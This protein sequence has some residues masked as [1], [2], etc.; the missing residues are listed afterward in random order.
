MIKVAIKKY[1]WC[2]HFVKISAWK[3]TTKG[4]IKKRIIFVLIFLGLR[5]L[6]TV[7][8]TYILMGCYNRTLSH[9]AII[10]VSKHYPVIGEHIVIIF[11]AQIA[12]KQAILMG[13]L[14]SNS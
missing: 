2:V 14:L 11:V 9:D 6:K 13:Y 1:M 7:S 8:S 4:M 12:C 5:C 10:M 3:R